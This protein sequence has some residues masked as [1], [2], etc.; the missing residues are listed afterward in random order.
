M[1]FQ[2]EEYRQLLANMDIAKANL[3]AFIEAHRKDIRLEMQNGSSVYTDEQNRL[4]Q[5]FY[6]AL[7]ACSKYWENIASYSSFDVSIVDILVELI[8]NYEGVQHVKGSVTSVKKDYRFGQEVEYK[9]RLTFITPY[10]VSK[11]YMVDRGLVLSREKL[12]M[13][14]ATEGPREITF[15]YSVGD[16]LASKVD[17]ANF[18]YVQDFI[19]NLIDYKMKYGKESSNVAFR[20]MMKQFL[21]NRMPT[22]MLYQ[23]TNFQKGPLSSVRPSQIETGLE[24]G[25][26]RL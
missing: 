18:P 15:Y 10:Y 1:N 17:F 9:E 12:A 24:D 23:A 16:Q 6:D 11:K 26:L 20:A 2:S 3:R 8:S 4:Q 22:I 5:V 7:N 14:D 21:D 13:E 25:T 19:D